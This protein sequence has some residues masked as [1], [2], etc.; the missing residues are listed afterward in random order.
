MYTVNIIIKHIYN[1]YED[2]EK[3]IKTLKIRWRKTNRNIK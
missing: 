2:N 1:G 3:K